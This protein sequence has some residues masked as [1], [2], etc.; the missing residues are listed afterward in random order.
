MIGGTEDLSAYNIIKKN[1]GTT[2]ISTSAS[3]G[4]ATAVRL[5][6]RLDFIVYATGSDWTKGIHELENL[7]K[8]KIGVT[9][10]T[11]SDLRDY[12]SK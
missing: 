6:S 10:L 11:S 8:P 2:Y 9:K 3:I 4:A 7:K 12:V 5:S 1:K